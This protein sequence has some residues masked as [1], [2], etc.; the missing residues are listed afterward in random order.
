MVHRHRY[1]PACV[2]LVYRTTSGTSAV[3]DLDV[4]QRLSSAS[5]L[6]VG[7]LSIMP[8]LFRSRHVNCPHQFLPGQRRARAECMCVL[9][10]THQHTSTPQNTHKHTITPPSHNE[11]KG[12]RAHRLPC[13]LIPVPHESISPYHSQG[14][15][16]YGLG[17]IPLPRPSH[18]DGRCRGYRRRRGNGG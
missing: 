3:C 16:G 8:S 14:R 12:R 11:S 5:L 7:C 6:D 18:T 4:E 13:F 10:N 9:T 17:I 1:D 15:S 2:A